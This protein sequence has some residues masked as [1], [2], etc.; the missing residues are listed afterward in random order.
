MR[1]KATISY[2][3]SKYLGFQKQ[4][5]TRNTV[6]ETIEKALLSLQINSSITAS[7][8]TDAGVHATGQVIHFDLPDFWND[9]SKLQVSLNRKLS[10]ISFKYIAPTDD[11]FHARFSAKKRVYRYLFK[12]STLSVFEKNYVSHYANYN[13][14]MLHVALKKF[15][16]EHNFK[17]FMKTGTETHTTVRKI[18]KTYIKSK[19]DYH[20]IYFVANG[21]LRSQVRMMIEA[22]MQCAKGDISLKNLVSQIEC[23]EKYTTRLADGSG[24]YLSKVYY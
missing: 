16:G 9:M 10:D 22:S 15:E 6:S 19:N 7:G 8:R 23:T 21:F 1:V 3:G 20:C 17:Y 18:F 2:D 14:E 4:K 5:N 24:L 13:Q 12:S 11:T